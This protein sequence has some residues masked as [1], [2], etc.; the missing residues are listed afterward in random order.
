M[1]VF[2]YKEQANRMQVNLRNEFE[3]SGKLIEIVMEMLD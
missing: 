1:C 2:N 3:E